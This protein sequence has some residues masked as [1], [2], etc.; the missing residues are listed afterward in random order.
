QRKKE[1]TPA[2]YK[3]F[4]PG[5]SG[6]KKLHSFIGPVLAKS[7]EKPLTD[8]EWIFEINWDGYPAIA[9]LKNEKPQFYSRNGIS[10]LQKFQ[11]I[12]EDLPRQTHQMVLDGE[13]L[14]YDESGSP[15]FQLLQQIGENPDLALTYQVFDLLWLNGHSTTELPLLQRKELLRDALVETDTI[16][17]C[18]HIAE[19]GVEFFNHLRKMKLEGMIAKKADSLYLE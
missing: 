14:A 18:E 10:F 3:K 6:E 17:F 16:K 1:L 4:N 7:S 19:D 13:I 15:R 5:L 2:Q 9:N 8:K 11:K 12:V